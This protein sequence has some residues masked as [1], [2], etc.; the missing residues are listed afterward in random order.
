M[1]V[2][3]DKY[4][5]SDFVME[6]ETCFAIMDDSPVSYGHMLILPKACKKSYFDLTY[7]E[8]EDSFMLLKNCKAYIDKRLFP[9]GYD[10]G[11]N[12]GAW[13]G[14]SVEHC[15]IDLIPRYAGDVP[16]TELKGGVR[17]IL[18]QNK[19]KNHVKK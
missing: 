2:F 15:C 11:I 18:K 7:K 4:L 1:C 5:H 16:A 17:N 19:V 6:N 13:A 10:I 14:Q 3:C 8:H 9:D 12:I